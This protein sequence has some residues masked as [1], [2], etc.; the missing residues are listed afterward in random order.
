MAY[1][2]VG[3]E[4]QGP[5]EAEKAAYLQ[6]YLQSLGL[7]HI[8]SMP[9]PD[10]RVQDG[11]RPNVAAVLPG[12]DQKRT[13]W[14][15]SHLDVVPAGDLELWQSDPFEL[16]QS[17]DLIYGRGVEDNQHGL[18]AS[19]LCLQSFLHNNQQPEKNLGLLLVADEETGNK[20]GLNYVL[21]KHGDIFQ[22]QDE[23][24][25]PD[26]GTP[27]S[28]LLEVAEKG[29]L[30]LKF[31]IEGRQCHASTPDK[32]LNSLRVAARLILEL[33]KLPEHFPLQDQMFAP[34]RSTF[35]PTKKEANVPNVNTIPGRD[36]FSL[37]CRV[38]P[39]YNLQD[40][41][42]FCQ[43]VAAGLAA[44]T[45]TEIRVEVTHQEDPAPRTDPEH[46]LVQNFIESISVVYGRPPTPQGIGGGTVAAYLRRAG[47]PAVVWSTLLGNAHQPNEHTSVSNIINDAK[48]MALQLLK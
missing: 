33:E 37:D 38:L 20:Y 43:D 11:K 16:Q 41:F 1:Q 28:S 5:G 6:Q 8:V 39:D 21:D 13:F 19:L 47:Y 7:Q 10:P 4:N 9:A 27:D 14:I 25:V 26:F 24:L 15:V 2:A 22:E 36:V 12:K 45:R 30:W 34:P 32:G 44:E 18:V 31:I 46:P 42:L 35:E 40:V 29:L 23:F 48:V 3:P 17:G